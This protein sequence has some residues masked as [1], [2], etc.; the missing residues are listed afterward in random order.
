MLLSFDVLPEAIAEHDHWHTHE[1]LPER[2]SIP[3]FLRGTRWIATQGGPRYMV[4]YE[5]ADLAVLTSAA[6]L[7]RLDNPSAWTAT[8]MPHYRG[9]RRGFCSVSCSHGLGT[10]H[11]AALVRLK[12]GEGEAEALRSR[13]IRDLLPGLPGR[14]G[15]GGAHLLEGAATPPMTNEQR[16]RGADA[17]VASAVVVTGY[18]EGALA[19][20]VG[21]IPGPAQLYRIDYSLSREELAA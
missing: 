8:V 15:V 2:L 17:P 6:Y 14:P 19:E 12:P 3:G 11:V 21:G 18:E 1:H 4:L 5:V 10:G 7:E 13:L 9:M 16:I 20:A